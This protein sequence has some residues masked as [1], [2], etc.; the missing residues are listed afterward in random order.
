LI[1]GLEFQAASTQM[2]P[3]DLLLLYT[4]GLTE[5]MNQGGEQFGRERLGQLVGRASTLPARELLQALRRSLEGFVGDRPLRDDLT[6]VVCRSV[7]G[8]QTL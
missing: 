4:D 8:S 2:Q 3:G 6:L 7:D 5:A 1:E